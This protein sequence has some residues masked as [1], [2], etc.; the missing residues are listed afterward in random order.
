MGI[1]IE[2]YDINRYVSYQARLNLEHYGY[3]PLVIQKQDML[4]IDKK[5]DV[6]IIDIP[7]GVYSPFSYEQQL[8]LLKGTLSLAPKLLL[9]SHIPM[10]QE[11]EAMGYTI[12]DQAM[13]KKGNFQRYMTLCFQK[14]I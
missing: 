13:I 3:D 12:L 14:A 6:T 1:D 9:V 10:N 4:T 7:Y 11:L 8:E 5:Y 2:G